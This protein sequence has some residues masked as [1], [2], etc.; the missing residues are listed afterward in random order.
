[1]IRNC[2]ACYIHVILEQICA[3]SLLTVKKSATFCEANE[4]KDNF[5]W[6]AKHSKYNAYNS[7]TDADNI[8]GTALEL[9]LEI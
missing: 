6:M 3:G 1:M 9:D 2:S 5:L 7:F 4:G 8:S